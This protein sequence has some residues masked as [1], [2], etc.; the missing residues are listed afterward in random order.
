MDE[1]WG[2]RTSPNDPGYPWIAADLQWLKAERTRGRKERKVETQCERFWERHGKH[3]TQKVSKEKIHSSKIAAVLI[4]YKFCFIEIKEGR[5]WRGVASWRLVFAL[6]FRVDPVWSLLTFW[7]R[8]IRKP[9]YV[10]RLLQDHSQ[11]EAPPPPILFL[12]VFLFCL[13]RTPHFWALPSCSD[14]MTGLT[15]PFPYKKGKRPREN[16]ECTLFLQSRSFLEKNF[17]LEEGMVF[18]WGRRVRHCR[19]DVSFSCVVKTQKCWSN[20][21]YKNRTHKDKI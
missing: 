11:A 5:L 15:P 3:T 10:T 17:P 4:S 19:A 1:K 8:I 18:P 9:K 13:G 16:R 12:R 21:I 20:K 2:R 7:W 14:L 6:V